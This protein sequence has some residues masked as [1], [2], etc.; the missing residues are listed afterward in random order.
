VQDDCHTWFLTEADSTEPQCIHA[1]HAIICCAA[2]A[3]PEKFE[4]DDQ[5]NIGTG[6]DSD[7][8][9]SQGEPGATDFLL[10]YV[11]NLSSSKVVE[12][13]NKRLALA[14]TLMSSLVRAKCHGRCV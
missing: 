7:T 3:Q 14:L 11:S 4:R 5:D 12:D 13:K 2:L 9:T 10:E 6:E 1:K 8:F